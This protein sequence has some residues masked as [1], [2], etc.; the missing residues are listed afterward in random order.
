MYF[1]STA[2]WQVPKGM[3]FQSLEKHIATTRVSFDSEM[4]MMTEDYW[5]KHA[6]ETLTELQG[7]LTAP[8]AHAKW[9]LDSSFWARPRP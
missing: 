6:T 8:Q 1:H 5:V 9:C 3:L 4:V 7:R 2:S